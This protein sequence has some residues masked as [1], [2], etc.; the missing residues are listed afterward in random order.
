MQPRRCTTTTSGERRYDLPSPDNLP[1]CRR[2]GEGAVRAAAGGRGGGLGAGARVAAGRPR[3]ECPA[4]WRLP[5]GARRALGRGPA[6]A[7]AVVCA[8]RL[9]A[10]AGRRLGGGERAGRVLACG[11]A[12]AA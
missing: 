7:R 6:P 12:G 4:V 9:V 3:G 8:S 10:A 2:G 5:A 1:D 11:A